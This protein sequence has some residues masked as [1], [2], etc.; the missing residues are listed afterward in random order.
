M[1]RE[2]CPGCGSADTEFVQFASGEEETVKTTV[3]EVDGG[4]LELRT[5]NSC[6]AGIEVIL[7]AQAKTLITHDDY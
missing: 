7:R 5:C 3:S 4:R 2:L 1:N 6:G